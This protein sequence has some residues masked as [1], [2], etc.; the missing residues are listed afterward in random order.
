MSSTARKY[1][2]ILRTVKNPEQG[3]YLPQF[4]SD[5]GANKLIN[6]II[7]KKR[8]KIISNF[9]NVAASISFFRKIEIIT[10]T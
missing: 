1:I 8:L 9:K 7:F 10:F 3:K 4:L 5:T 2:G 6:A